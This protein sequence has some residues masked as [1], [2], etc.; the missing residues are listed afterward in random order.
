MVVAYV[1][2]FEQQKCQGAFM[3]GERAGGWKCFSSST[4]SEED[5]EAAQ[6]RT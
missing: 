4:V 2:R 5:P 3:V 6:G 1:S